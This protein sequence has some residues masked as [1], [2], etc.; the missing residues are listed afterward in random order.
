M[1][2]RYVNWLGRE[3][4]T[5]SVAVGTMVFIWML[6]FVPLW[7]ANMFIGAC[8]INVVAVLVHECSKR[9]NRNKAQTEQVLT[10]GGE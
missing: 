2:A 8:L 4:R 1:L 7:V 9:R 6:R 10:R 3:P 5:W